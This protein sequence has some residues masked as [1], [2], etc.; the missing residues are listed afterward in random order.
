MSSH[1]H[2]VLLRAKHGCD[3]GTNIDDLAVSDDSLSSAGQVGFSIY[4]V[5]L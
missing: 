5:E 2:L 4:L 3:V 1:L